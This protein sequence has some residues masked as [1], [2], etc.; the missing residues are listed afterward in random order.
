MFVIVE[1]RDEIVDGR[2][3]GEL[4]V[5]WREVGYLRSDE[6]VGFFLLVSWGV[7][8]EGYLVFGCCL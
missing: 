8:S 1:V 4:V 2:W 6:G 5:G 3:F 7:K